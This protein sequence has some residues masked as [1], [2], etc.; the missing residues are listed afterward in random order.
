MIQLERSSSI[1]EEDL[2]LFYVY[3][4]FFC[5]HVSVLCVHAL[6]EEARRGHQ[7]SETRVMDGFELLHGC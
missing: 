3:K 7:Y 2:F 5:V 4:C 1:L 6:T